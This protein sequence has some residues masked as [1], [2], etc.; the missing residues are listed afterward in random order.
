MGTWGS[1]TVASLLWGL[2][3]IACVHASR[4]TSV[5][6]DSLRPMDCSLPGSSV[7]GI[8]KARMLE[9][10]AVSSSRGSSPPRDQTLGLLV[11]YIGKRVP[12]H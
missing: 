8:L 5:V 10:V 4:V 9:W 12:Y 1:S 6:S 3:Q 7:R 11:S 2:G